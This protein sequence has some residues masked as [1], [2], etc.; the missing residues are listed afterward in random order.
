MYKTTLCHDGWISIYGFL[1]TAG[2][3]ILFS[4]YEILGRNYVPYEV[5][6]R[7][8]WLVIYYGVVNVILRMKMQKENFQVTFVVKIV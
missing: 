6:T 5:G 1:S 8:I 7:F 2:L 3:P 4:V